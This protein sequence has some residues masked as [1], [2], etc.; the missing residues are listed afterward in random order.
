MI[1]AGYRIKTVAS[2]TGVPRNTL[3]AWERRYKFV[4]PVRSGNHYRLYSELVARARRAPYAA[5]ILID[6]P[7]FHLRLGKALRRLGIP[8]IQFVAPRPRQRRPARR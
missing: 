5:A 7:G 3:L 1:A 8:V 6:Y 4:S 2:L